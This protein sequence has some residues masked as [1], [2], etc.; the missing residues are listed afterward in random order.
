MFIRRVYKILKSKY[1]D[2]WCCFIICGYTAI[3]ANIIHANSLVANVDRT[4]VSMILTKRPALLL[5]GF[6]FNK[7]RL[8]IRSQN[9][10]GL[11]VQ[12]KY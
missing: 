5:E 3:M 4:S 9:L 2:I 11:N 12:N 6:T 7:K 1:V 10:V 8:N